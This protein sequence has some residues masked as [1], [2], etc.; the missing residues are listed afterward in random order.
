M[1]MLVR[2]VSY[3][4]EAALDITETTIHEECHH[5]AIT[6]YMTAAKVSRLSIQ[7]VVEQ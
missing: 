2:T 5:T 6:M 1:N 7:E 3:G 4:P